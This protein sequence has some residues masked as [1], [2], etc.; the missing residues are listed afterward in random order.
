VRSWFEA[1]LKL[2]QSGESPYLMF[3]PLLVLPD[4][5]GDQ[6]RKAVDSAVR[7][8]GISHFATVVSDEWPTVV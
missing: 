7:G 3:G 6:L 2:L 4:E 8:P 5:S 1:Q